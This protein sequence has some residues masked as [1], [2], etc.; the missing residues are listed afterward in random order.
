[1][2]RPYKHSYL[3]FFRDDVALSFNGG[4]DCTVALHLLRAACA[5]KDSLKPKSEVSAPEYLQRMK[6]VHFVKPNEFVEIE[7]FREQI[8]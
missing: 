7:K 6:F 1:M 5:I 8:E 2:G 3:F 4:K